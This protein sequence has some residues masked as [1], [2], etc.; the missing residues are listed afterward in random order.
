MVKP[1]TIRIIL[2]LAVTKKW[3]IHQLDVNNAFL[4]GA[5]EEEVYMAQPPG[6]ENSDKSMVCKLTKALYGLKQAPRAWFDKLKTALIKFGFKASCCDPSLFT[7]L[8]SHGCIYIL[9]YVD[10]III[11][12][13]SLD[14]I[15]QL[16]TKLN[17]EFSLKQ[18]GTL[19]Y[20]L[21]VQ[22]KHLQDGSLFLSQSKYFGDLLER[23]NM[24]EAKG[25][26]TPMTSGLKLSKHG[27]N[28][29]QDPTLYRSIVGALQYATLTRPEISFAVN[30]VCQFLSQPLEEHWKAAKRI[31]RYLMG[32]LHHGLLLRPCI[33]SSPVSLLAFR[34]A[35][36]GADPDDR[37]S[38]SGFAIYFGPNLVSW[39]SKKQTLVARSSTEAEY[40]ALANTAA[41]VLWVQSLLQELHIPFQAPRILCDNMST[42]ALTH[43][44]IL[45]TRTKHMELDLFFVR[46]KVLAK[47]LCLSYSFT[48]SD[49]RYTHKSSL[50]YQI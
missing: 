18:L 36:W 6:F 2:S 50:I 46:E 29:F 3:H 44:P 15:Q 30:K 39:C 35:D 4:N 42:V 22:V 27:S 19:D 45:H 11:T 21:G 41:E 40:R 17:T 33:S 34:D 31:L 12:G 5:L 24:G 8:T 38:T 25:I 48:G 20:F 23:A 1:I 7:L 16:T 49:C 13:S 32:T 9:V 14:Q 47:N 28:Y 43:N 26:A 10:D 37:R